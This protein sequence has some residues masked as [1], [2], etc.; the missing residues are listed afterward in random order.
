MV[1]KKFLGLQI[2][3][4]LSWKNDTEQM[5]PKLSAACCA[6]RSM[7]HISSINTVKSIYYAY[8]HFVI[9]YGIILGGNSS[10]SGKI[11]TLQN[12]ILRIM[13]GAQPRTSCRNLFRRLQI[14]PLPCQY[15]VSLIKFVVN[16][17]EVFQTNLSIYR[18]LTL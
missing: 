17:K 10:I 4:H 6:V 11:F 8:F 3:N 18:S 12:K 9:K 2:H 1:N 15:I 5:I 13:A 16:N 14:P 7:D